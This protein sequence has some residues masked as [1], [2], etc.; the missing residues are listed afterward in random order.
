LQVIQ[1]IMDQLTELG[2]TQCAWAEFTR[3]AERTHLRADAAIALGSALTARTAAILLDQYQG[4]WDETVARIVSL[5]AQG[6]HQAVGSELAQLNALIDVG[7]HLTKPRKVVVAGAVNVGK[8]SLVNALVGYERCIVAPTPG[9]TRDVVTTTI[10]LGGWP[11]AL[12]DT[13]GF[14]DPEGP[15]E[16][17]GMRLARGAVDDADCCIWV[18]DASQKPIWPASRTNYLLVI[19]KIDLAVAWPLDQGGEAVRVSARTGEGLPQLVRE[20]TRRLVPMEPVP[21][22]A[23]PFMENLGHTIS[24]AVRLYETGDLESVARLLRATVGKEMCN[25]TLPS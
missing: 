3:H 1:L 14:R 13:A 6:E 5:C 25:A 23:V 17:E 11:V 7:L 21:G 22:L 10:A 2:A 15:V 24:E 16:Q 9:T 18:V 4:A 19:N 20:L 8:S 12:A